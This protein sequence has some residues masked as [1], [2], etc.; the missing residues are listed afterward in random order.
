VEQVCVAIQSYYDRCD[1]M[2]DN[3]VCRS[4]RAALPK[5]TQNMLFPLRRP[6]C[7]PRLLP[8]VYAVLLT[9]GPCSGGLRAQ[10]HVNQVRNRLK[11]FL[12]SLL[13][14]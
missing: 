1:A 13:D 7:S 10:A 9:F 14:K 5:V 6:A 2:V 12:P 3:E 8:G 4:M 11:A